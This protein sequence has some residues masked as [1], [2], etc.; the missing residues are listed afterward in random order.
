MSIEVKDFVSQQVVTA[1]LPKSKIFIFVLQRQTLYQ[2]AS[3][4]HFLPIV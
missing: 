4:F 1:N 2:D 3:K